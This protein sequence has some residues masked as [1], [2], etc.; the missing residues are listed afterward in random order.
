MKCVCLFPCGLR[1]APFLLQF[2]S[3][4]RERSRLA[5]WTRFAN[6]D[7][8]SW[9]PKP[10]NAICERH[11]PAEAIVER[12]PNLMNGADPSLFPGNSEVKG[13]KVTMCMHYFIGSRI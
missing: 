2:F 3:F 8:P 11:F 4:P 6:P 9:R 13:I 12:P 5:H 1:V 7:W 10:K